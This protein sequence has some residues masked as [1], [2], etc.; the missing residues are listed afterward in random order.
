MVG[1]KARGW[2]GV[3]VEQARRVRRVELSFQGILG[4][5]KTFY[6]ELEILL[7]QIYALELCF[8]KECIMSA[9]DS[10]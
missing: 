7:T 3:A 5:A 8:C 9:A 6:G 4:V 1:R 2:C 10:L